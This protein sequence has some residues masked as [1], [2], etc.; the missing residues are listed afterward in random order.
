MA[1]EYSA[2]YAQLHEIVSAPMKQLERIFEHD[3]EVS[4]FVRNKVNPKAHLLFS[5]DSYEEIVKA[6]QE[7]QMDECKTVI[8]KGARFS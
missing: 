3:V 2:D 4:L 1:K 5:N 6:L 8:E 7:L